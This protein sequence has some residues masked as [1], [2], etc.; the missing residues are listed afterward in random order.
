[1]ISDEEL[2]KLR[3]A[4][5]QAIE[6]GRMGLTITLAMDPIKVFAITGEILRLR[7]MMGVL[8]NAVEAG[9]DRRPE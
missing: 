8:Q 6:D 9:H 1:M 4:A 3:R 2:K 5:K 7:K